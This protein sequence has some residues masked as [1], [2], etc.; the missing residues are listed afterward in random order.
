MTK[1]LSADYSKVI[2]ALKGLA[3][4]PRPHG[5]KKLKGRMGYRVRIDDYRIIYNIND[6][7]LT[8]LFYQLEIEKMFMNDPN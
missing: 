8:V 3:N 6:I 2:K 1:I 5:Y 4:N 7:I